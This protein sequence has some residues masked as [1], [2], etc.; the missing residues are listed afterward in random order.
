MSVRDTPRQPSALC[1]LKAMSCILGEYF[2]AARG[3]TDFFRTFVLVFCNVIEKFGGQRP[4]FDWRQGLDLSIGELKHRTG[5]LNSLYGRF[6]QD[7]VGMRRELVQ[8]V[9]ESRRIDRPSHEFARPRLRALYKAGK[10]AARGDA[11][12]EFPGWGFPNR[13]NGGVC[14]PHCRKRYLLM[15][16]FMAT[17]EASTPGPL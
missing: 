10:P 15:I 7:F 11:F 1:A 6:Y 14:S 9:S 13:E 2:G 4:Y 17:A 3:R 8:Q 12:G 16:L 5:E